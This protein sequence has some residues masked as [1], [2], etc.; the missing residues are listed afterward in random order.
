MGDSQRSE[1]QNRQQ[2]S[3]NSYE[4]SAR[5]H[6]PQ[7]PPPTEVEQHQSQHEV[8]EPASQLEAVFASIP[9]GVIVYDLKGKIRRINPAA[10][11]LFEL[12]S[13]DLCIGTSYH[14]FIRRYK[15]LDE[16]QQ[17][18][19][20]KHRSISHVISGDTA[21]G[22]QEDTVMIRVPSGRN[23]YV[24]ISCAPVL[25]S[26]FH[27]IGT[28]CVFHDITD[29]R[30]NEL[31]IR[32]ANAALL[33]LLRAI[34]DIP[35]L[36]D[37]WS[38]EATLLLPPA[39]SFIG[40]QL[41]ELISQI[42]ECKLGLLLSLGPPAD[43]LYY[44]AMWGLTPEQERRLRENS[45]R[46]S[47]SDFFDEKTLAHLYAH[48][49]VSITYDRIRVPFLDRSDLGSRNMLL[50]PIFLGKQIAGILVTARANLN[51]GYTFEE[52]ALVKA[53]ATL[54]SL[55][56]ECV[57][58]L[59]KLD[60]TNTR[61]LVL[62]E[63]HQ[64][65]NEFLNLTSHELRTPL[66]ATM[67]NI[68]LA[69]RRL[70]A[71]KRH[72]TDPSETLNRYIEQ[73]RQPLEHASQSARQQEGLIRNMIDDARI[74]SHTLTL[75]MSRGNLIKLVREVVVKQQQ[76]AP[77]RR[78]ILDI[79]HTEETVPVIANADRIKQVIDTYLTNA[80]NY[81]PA[82]RPVTVQ[83]T[84]EGSMARVSVHDEGPG[85]PPEEQ[86]HIW[87]RFYRAKGIAVQHELDLSRGLSL[88]ICQELIK[89]HHGS[90]GLQSVPDRGSTFWFTLPVATQQK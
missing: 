68:Q 32:Q 84:V 46:F 55:V 61:E 58:T 53:V 41:V 48:K 17:P 77:E 38:P 83:L 1:K 54:I 66:T 52:I 18:I 36:V 62:Q 79:R 16:N 23:V 74:Q 35:A 72:V 14:Q 4:I 63:T 19:A 13:E 34:A 64:L 9:V 42:L 71:L 25:D 30:W 57:R 81:S 15:I 6:M 33:I 89:Y 7:A 44:V 47:L 29:R 75:H 73:V 20:L 78:I 21:S 82:D 69:L 43:H 37:R 67:G 11:T 31:Q 22:T 70:E 5:K 60:G 51:N 8:V 65:I 49:E 76:Q 90:V 59:N 50:T 26:Q 87:K 40:Q 2:K 86:E 56:N 28:V 24:I 88:Y 85:I 12:A 39:M 10:L 3:K 27:R 80:L 45:G